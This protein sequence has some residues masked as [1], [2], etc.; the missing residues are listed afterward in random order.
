MKGPLLDASDEE[1]GF[2]HDLAR[3]SR[4]VSIGVWPNVVLAVVLI[5][6]GFPPQGRPW[7][8]LLFG[9][10]IQ[11]TAW[12]TAYLA[13]RVRWP[14]TLYFA[15]HLL[16]VVWVTVMLWF[17][18]G[19][20]C[21]GASLFYALIVING[22]T[23][24]GSHVFAAASALSYSAMI[25]LGRGPGMLDTQQIATVLFMWLGLHLVAEYLSKISRLLRDRR[26][27]LASAH[28]RLSR[29]RLALEEKVQARTTRLRD[30][31][32]AFADA[33]RSPV[34]AIGLHADLF[35]RRYAA[36]APVDAHAGL[37]RI[38]AE[39]SSCDARISAM[40]EL[41]RVQ[42]PA[43]PGRWVDLDAVAGGAL[44]ELRPRID[45][46]AVH[47]EVSSLPRVW[48]QPAKLEILLTNL[49]DN[50]IK[51]VP[52]GTGRV[53]VDGGQVDGRTVWFSVRDNGVGIP[54]KYR[55]VVFELFRRVP[56]SEQLVDGATVPGAGVGLT[57]VREIVEQH[58]GRIVLHSAAGEGT[59]VEV[60]LPASPMAGAWDGDEEVVHRV[61]DV[62]R[63]EVQH[64]AHVRE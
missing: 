54:R 33:V 13:P 7:M 9:F 34:N 5:L 14:R 23:F 49:L 31:L 57:I 3:L 52:R 22:G 19:W 61:P 32:F 51:Y 48:G 46:K 15:F 35:L 25:A 21:P 8:V 43:E 28:V 58:G 30:E 55:D 45:E 39:A 53:L 40:L 20:A 26:A 4:V 44:A 63:S 64:L 17:G 11:V 6:L 24:G 42:G 56:A 47:M 59:T 50:A 18:G 62:L 36:G 41:L 2:R 12:A 1:I 60:R 37:D 16:D 38:E 27:E 29:E 10:M